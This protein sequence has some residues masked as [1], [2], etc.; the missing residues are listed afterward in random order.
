MWCTHTRGTVSR[1]LHHPDVWVIVWFD[2]A[3]HRRRLVC[4]SNCIAFSG[5]KE[6]SYAPHGETGERRQSSTSST[7]RLWS[8]HARLRLS[9]AL[10]R[11]PRRRL[12]V[13]GLGGRRSTRSTSPVCW[14]EAP[15]VER[16]RAGLASGLLHPGP[17]PGAPRRPTEVV[18]WF[19]RRSA[20]RKG[21]FPRATA[22]WIPQF[23]GSTWH[24]PWETS[25]RTARPRQR[26][27]LVALTPHQSI[28]VERLVMTRSVTERSRPVWP[29]QLPRAATSRLSYTAAPASAGG[30]RRS[31]CTSVAYASDAQSRVSVRQRMRRCSCTSA[32]ALGL[33]A[34]PAPFL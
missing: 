34:A 27:C 16:A 22:T 8:V 5:H 26:T 28:G 10:E 32:G 23:Q 25:P 15:V 6:A 30:V 13:A 9:G 31:E 11:N 14:T 29:R 24:Q 4:A 18:G 17:L 1:S 20:G 3:R 19:R 12:S 2:I 21:D 7:L 33:A